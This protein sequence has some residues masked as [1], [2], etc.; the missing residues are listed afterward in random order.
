MEEIKEGKVN[1]NKQRTQS[2]LFTNV[3]ET[4]LA[5]VALFMEDCLG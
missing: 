1:V 4:H 3:P 2:W 5:S